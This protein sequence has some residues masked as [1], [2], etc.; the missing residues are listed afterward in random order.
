MTLFP[1][2]CFLLH[3]DCITWLFWWTF[4]ANRLS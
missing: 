1:V 2:L 3:V 4:F